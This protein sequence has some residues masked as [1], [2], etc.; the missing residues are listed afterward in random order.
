[1][2]YDDLPAEARLA[3]LE[4][5]QAHLTDAVILAD[6]RGRIL[7]VNRA[8]E[9]MTGWP[10]A[11]V[12]G[13]TPGSLLRSGHH[14]PEF[15]A[16]MWEHLQSGL[17]W[18]GRIHSARRDG[19]ELIQD[20][21]VVPVGTELPPRF[22]IGVRRDVTERVRLEDLRERLLWQAALQDPLTGLPNR[23][24]FLDRLDQAAARLVR[25]PTERYAVLFIDLDRF[26][27]INDSFGHEAGDRLLLEIARRIS[28][29]V[30]PDDTVARL[31]GDE[32]TLLLE[33]V[34][35]VAHAH[36]AAARVATSIGRPLAVAGSDLRVTASIGI[37]LGGVGDAP[38][39]VLQNADRAMYRAKR[40]GGARRVVFDPSMAP[41]VSRRLEREQELK[42]GLETGQIRPH[43][44]P[45]LDLLSGRLVG[46]EALARWPA[47]PERAP[48]EYIP[49]AEQ[50]GM[51][52]QLGLDVAEGSLDF[53]SRWK[54]KG[55][56]V[57]VAI[58]LSAVQ[59]HASTLPAVLL[60]LTD[61]LG[62][63]PEQLAVEITES[64][65]MR[66]V[67][68]TGRIIRLL[69]NR[70]FQ[71]LLD[72]FGTGHSSLSLLHRL[73]VDGLKID[74]SFIARVVDDPTSRAVVAS[75]VGLAASLGLTTVAE[76]IETDAQRA[77]LVDLGCQRGQGWLWSRA[78]PRDRAL[79]FLADRGSTLL[80]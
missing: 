21:T 19:S 79:Q 6:D 47:M 46:F 68:A 67:A 50:T 52:H 78:M 65:A 18:E 20:A 45:I 13:Q 62:V 17:T 5:V 60:G 41:T 63:S 34:T 26:K 77:A 2:R 74:R 3:W 42:V 56:A 72:D 58:N 75:I 31:G 61:R 1:L 30:R 39:D 16:G 23:R 69:R 48:D 64:T 28:P 8:W 7:Y 38:R 53:V 36:A 44:Q 80:G 57:R 51:I 73:P 29:T 10:A 66:D 14:P 59:L 33:G 49:L 40:D 27:L 4:L 43:F 71:V 24:L 25:R 76:G 55:A 15:W 22:F 35:D 32:F 37:A 12:I 9:R 54:G 11:D 70:G